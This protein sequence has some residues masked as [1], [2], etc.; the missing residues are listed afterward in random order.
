MTFKLGTERVKAINDGG[1]SLTANAK[2]KRLPR[3]AQKQLPDIAPVFSIEVFNPK[4][5]NLI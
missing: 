2:F 4:Q 5:F 1:I 3:S